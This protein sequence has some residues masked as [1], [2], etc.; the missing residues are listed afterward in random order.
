MINKNRNRESVF[1]FANINLLGKCNADC[2]FC[3]GKD[4]EKELSIHDQTKIHFSEWKNF[5]KFID[6]CKE[7][8]IK[9]IYLTG[10]N[11]DSLL[12]KY[13]SELRDYIQSMGFEFGIRTNGYKALSMLDEIKKCNGEI[14]VSVNSLIPDVNYDIMKRIDIPDWN[15]IIPEIENIRISI[16]VNRYNKDEFFS[17]IDYVAQFKNVKYIQVRRIST[18]TRENFLMPDIK[19]YE[20]LYEDVKNKY[21]LIGNFYLAQQFCISGIEVD[22]WRTVET[23]I[24]SINYFTDG[25][26]SNKYFVVEG[27]LEQ[28]AQQDVALKV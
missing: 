25:T 5:N 20:A 11:T 16:V 13:F 21:K 12:Y 15:K 27:Y 1:D 18:D 6:G 3:L 22:F 14:G 17:I 23:S 4:I 28:Q 2:F 26:L 24:N 9:K 19:I 10:Q 8:N 7:K